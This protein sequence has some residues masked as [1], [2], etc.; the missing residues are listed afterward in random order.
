MKL[1]KAAGGLKQ[2][3]K[4]KV[5]INTNMTGYDAI[6]AQRK[7]DRQTTDMLYQIDNLHKQVDDLRADL[8]LLKKKH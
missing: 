4:T 3:K 2:D 8:E 1:V 5:L 6:I 7:K